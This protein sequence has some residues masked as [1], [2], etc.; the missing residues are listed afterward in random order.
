VSGV[1][2]PPDDVAPFRA[3]PAPEAPAEPAPEAPAEAPAPA[4]A[5]AKKPR[6]SVRE[7]LWSFG[8]W[9]RDRY[10]VMDPRTAG[11]YRIVIGFLCV[12]HMIRHWED[13]RT[14]YSNDGVLT[15]HYHLFRPSSGSNFSAFHA[16]SSIGE[17]HLAF[18]LAT[19]C[20]FLMMIGW[21]ARLFTAISFLLVTSLDNRR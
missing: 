21:R 16:F 7:A 9:F 18:G 20:H 17:V 5:A 4:P 12:A 1:S 3:E 8:A 2:N 6:R 11:L 15:N 14:F 13:A 19:L 10:F